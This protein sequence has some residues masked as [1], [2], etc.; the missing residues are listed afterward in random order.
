MALGGV[1]P[2]LIGITASAQVTTGIV[3]GTVYDSA[4]NRVSGASVQA[5]S[6][7]GTTTTV[8]TGSNGVYRMARLQ[9]GVYEMTVSASGLDTVSDET[10]KVRLGGIVNKGFVLKGADIDEVITTARKQKT[11]DFGVASTGLTV[12]VAEVFERTPLPRSLQGITLLT[13]GA[14]A[15]DDAFS[16]NGQSFSSLGGSS[17]A[18][19]TYYVNGMAITD[20]R[21]FIGSSTVPFEFYGSIDTKTGGFPAEFGRATGGVSNA[22]TKSGNNEWHFGANAFASLDALRN[23]VPDRIGAINHLDQRE[24]LESN[25]YASG[26]IIKDRLFFYAMVSPRKYTSS[27]T[28]RNFTR[29][30]ITDGNGDKIRDDRKYLVGS[31]ITLD[32]TGSRS[33]LLRDDPF[34]GAKID[35]NITD[36]HTLEGTWFRDKSTAVTRNFNLTFAD[37]TSDV[38]TEEEIASLSATSGGDVLI[39]KYTGRFTDWLTVSAMYGDQTFD[40]TLMQT[41][42]DCPIISDKR[43]VGDDTLKNGA[44]RINSC[45][46]TG[47]PL[48]LNDSDARQEIRIDA[49]M[50]FDFIG[51]H[52][53]RIGYDQ[54]KLSSS[55]LQAYSGNGAYR[56]FS[57]T[58]ARYQGVIDVARVRVRTLDG[59]YRVDEK[60]Y[61]AQDA[62]D[63]T[64]RLTLNL[65]IR[66]DSF[67]NQNPNGESFLKLSNQ[68]APRLSF[69]YDAFGDSR[70]TLKGGWGRYFLGVPS[71]TNMRLAGNERDGY[72][73]YEL[74]STNGNAVPTL[75]KTVLYQRLL[76][77]GT[78]KDP[79]SLIDANIK[80]MYVDELL[81]GADHDFDNGWVVGVNFT[82]RSLKSMLEDSAIDAGVIRYCQQNGITGCEDVWTGFDQYVLTNPGNDMRINLNLNAATAKVL[83]VAVGEEFFANISAETLGYPK[84]SRVYDAIEFKFD[85]DFSDNFDLHGSYTF[86]NL[87]GNYEGSVKSDN[88]QTD[89][90][91]TQDFD[92]PGL[93]DGQYG[94]SPNHRAHK[95]KAWGSYQLTDEIVI[96]GLY[97]LTSPRQF[98]CI[99]EHPTDGFAAAYGTAAN[100]CKGKL[101]QR[102]TAFQGDWISRLDMT[103]TYDASELFNSA[104][105]LPGKLKFRVDVFNLFNAQGATDFDE[106]GE[107]GAGDGSPLSLIPDARYGKPLSYQSPRTI[108]FGVKYDY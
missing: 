30:P 7:R 41:G 70:T 60:A 50:Y 96:G 65:G 108:R 62:W 103:L 20:F 72:K 59:A 81:V 85:R 89:A 49:D 37:A 98:G 8:I 71:N 3:T 39:A 77:D 80:P 57:S 76:S 63:V 104:G 91:L 105:G 47:S 6:S 95:F 90:G 58:N 31:T 48:R 53:L 82:H 14:V 11:F 100:Y 36:N 88:G 99:G 27:G 22:V 74:I 102:G 34:Y 9:I 83:G 69:A 25:F 44:N 106:T 24:K 101:V 75:G 29:T 78:V 84:G 17:I 86:S 92:Q 5:R 56:L 107:S 51:E 40:Q 52:H 79:S 66:N 2:M 16:K 28:F 73:Y 1:A 33:E 32:N 12:D 93:V 54:E 38:F 68:W 43:T 21:N 26:P 23:D 35:F 45:E 64:D 42:K 18:E 67:D 15:G 61:Y 4:G 10:V 19:N 97:T 94:K 55:T 13:P 87:E 46:A